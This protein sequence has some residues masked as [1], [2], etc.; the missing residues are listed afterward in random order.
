MLKQLMPALVLA[1]AAFCASQ[2]ALAQSAS[3]YPAKP[4]HII[5]TFTSGGAPDILARQIGDKL[6][7]AGSQPVIVD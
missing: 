6:G 2:P 1:G 3:T 4:I 7:A 5:V